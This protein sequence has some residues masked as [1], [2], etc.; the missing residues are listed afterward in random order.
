[1]PL[2]PASDRPRRDGVD[3]DRALAEISGEIAHA[4]FERGLGHA[5]HV[6][7]RH[8]LLGAVIGQRQQRAAVLHQRLGALGQRG[9]GVAGD[10]QRLGEIVLG[11]VDI[12]PVELLLV[13]KGDGVD[14]EIER[15]PLLG[16]RR[17]HGFDARLVGHVAGQHELRAD[18]VRERLDPLLDGVALISERDLG[19]L[20][21]H[22]LGDAPG[23]RPVI[24][25]AE[26]D[27][28]LA[29][30]QFAAVGHRASCLW[31]RRRFIGPQP[32]VRK[33]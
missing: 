17:E 20:V 1:M 13:G 4:R 31:K 9:E 21:G 5:H 23:D 14:Q 26:H 25:D 18:L 32:P 11:R 33:A 2:R 30:H 3:P 8:H 7:M 24:G 10:Q 12:A 22:G 27:A 15:A 28:A 19:A 6:V 29:R 16:D